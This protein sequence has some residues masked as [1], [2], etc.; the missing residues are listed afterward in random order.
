MIYKASR[1]LR[2]SRPVSSPICSINE[3]LTK[4]A[5]EL[6]T[7]VEGFGKIGA[8]ASTWTWTGSVLIKQLHASGGQIVKVNDLCLIVTLQ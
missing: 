4:K 7:R 3:H 2:N 6:S 1:E 5:D 8:I